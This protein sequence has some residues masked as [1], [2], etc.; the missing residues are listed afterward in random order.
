MTSIPSRIIAAF[1]LCGACLPAIAAEQADAPKCHYVRIAELPLRYSGPS[2]EI[3]AEGSINGSRATMLVDTGAYGTVLTSTGSERR[4]LA[5]RAT[6]SE[7]RGIGGTA[8]VYETRVEELAVGPARSGATWLQVLTDF[9]VPPSYDAIVGAPFLLQAD[10]ELSLATKK[11]RFFRPSKCADSFLG[12]WDPAAIEI[13]FERSSERDPN[14]QFTVLINGMKMR[15]VIDTGASITIIGMRAAERL[16]L[17][18]GAPGVTRLSDAVGVGTGRVARWSTM[19]DTF[20]IG[21]EIVRNAQ[22]GVIAW[23]DDRVDVLLGADFLRA[24][25]VLF[26]MS[27]RKIYLSYVGGQPF[28]RGRRVEPWLQA[29]AEA[30]NTDAQFML[31]RMYTNGQAGAE[32]P[33]LAASWLEKAAGGGNPHANLITGR[34]LLLQG[35]AEAGAA[36]IRYALDKLPSDRA[37]ALWLYIARVLG[38]QAELAKSE[39]AASFARNVD[40]AWPGPVADFYL[41]KI[42]AEALLK[43]AGADAGTARERRCEALHAM[44]EWHGAHGE[45]ER[46]A[47]LDAQARS[48]CGPATS[49]GAAAGAGVAAQP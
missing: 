18:L 38:K 3:T 39:L 40:N 10:M 4:K 34:S 21:D 17:K 45:R 30:G 35:F 27:Q 43:R 15:A 49:P 48:Q 24:H 36:R 25:R 41:G 20:Q 37:A 44:S 9:G 33:A 29:E 16:G 1:A 26:A 32:D 28:G 22:V 8:Q 5:L 46:A 6:R 23:D 11:L 47:A 12:Y 14:P 19:F 7:A 42:T 31:A 2:L 13:P